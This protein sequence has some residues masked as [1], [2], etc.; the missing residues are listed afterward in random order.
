MKK[1][2]VRTGIVGSGFSATFHFEALR[3]VYGTDVEVIGVH[4]LDVEG[5]K[6]YA[7]PVKDGFWYT[8]GDPLNYLQAVLEY[9]LSRDDISE[10][11]KKYIKGLRI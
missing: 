6:A 4:S 11:L 1:K 9:A 7:Q 5:G 10:D 2:T 8:T 3:K